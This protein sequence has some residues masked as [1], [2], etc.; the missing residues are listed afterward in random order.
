M[1]FL[2]GGLMGQSRRFVFL[3]FSL[4]GGRNLFLEDRLDSSRVSRF[5]TISLDGR[6][7]WIE[8]DGADE[9]VFV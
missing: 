4:S 5:L 1:L 2:L 6:G 8:G 9:R 7:R 3:F